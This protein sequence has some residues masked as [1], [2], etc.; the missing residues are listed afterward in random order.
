MKQSYDGEDGALSI[1]GLPYYT[2]HSMNIKDKMVHGELVKKSKSGAA[3]FFNVNKY[4]KRYCHVDFI[5]KEVTQRADY[6]PETKVKRISFQNI[7]E[8][9]YEDFDENGKEKGCNYTFKFKIV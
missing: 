8:I 5:R 7:I 4:L 1:Q 2:S 3:N 9:N 6:H